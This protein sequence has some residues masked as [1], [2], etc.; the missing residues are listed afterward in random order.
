MRKSISMILFF[1]LGVFIAWFTEMPMP[2]ESDELVFVDW[3][4]L[5]N[6]VCP[7]DND[8]FLVGFIKSV[9]RF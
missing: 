2:S 4:D 8:G 6:E 3:K 7:E 9:F 1:F 5:E